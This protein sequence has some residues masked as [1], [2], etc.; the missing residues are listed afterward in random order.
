MKEIYNLL[1]QKYDNVMITGS[2]AVYIYANEYNKDDTNKDKIEL[3]DIDP[4]DIDF[5]FYTTDKH[6]KLFEILIKEIN[7]GNYKYITKQIS[8][9][10]KTF[11]SDNTLIKSFDIINSYINPKNII[12]IDNINLLSIS[13]LADA[14]EEAFVLKEDKDKFEKHYKKIDIINKMLK[15]NFVSHDE[16]DTPKKEL[17]PLVQPKSHDNKQLKDKLRARLAEKKKEKQ[18]SSPS[19]LS[20]KVETLTE[21]VKETAQAST[22]LEQNINKAKELLQKMKEKKESSN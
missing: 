10:S 14:Y 21:Q 17:K 9:K 19:E 18:E 15:Y 5:I 4:Q 22:Q 3:K 16:K 6:Q 20:Q 12:T 7:I 11:T 8:G 2:W 13:Q 1:V